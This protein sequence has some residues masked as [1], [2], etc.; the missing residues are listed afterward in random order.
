MLYKTTHDEMQMA[1]LPKEVRRPTHNLQE[2]EHNGQQR[3]QSLPHAISVHFPE[4]IS[5]GGE[6]Y[7][8]DKAQHHNRAEGTETIRHR[9]TIRSA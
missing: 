1:S 4:A 2:A 6:I 9:K 8:S 3:E 7:I 5:A